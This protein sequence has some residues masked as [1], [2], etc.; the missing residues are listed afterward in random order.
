MTVMPVPFRISVIAAFAAALLLL[1]IFLLIR[2]RR[3]QA[4]YAVLWVAT[5]GS[6]LVLA[7]WRDLLGLVSGLLGIAYP[8][9][10][11]FVLGAVFVLVVL[12]HYSTVVSRLADENR[13]LAQRLA[14]LQARLEEVAGAR[15][16]NVPK[17]RAA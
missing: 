11:L 15:D 12:L 10:A 2:S 17:D 14:L 13:Q 7:L 3:L 16:A 9:S 1:T 5:G 4:R 8:P 6:L